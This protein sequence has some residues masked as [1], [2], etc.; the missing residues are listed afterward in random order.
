MISEALSAIV[1]GRGKIKQELGTKYLWIGIVLGSL[2][3]NF[4]ILSGHVSAYDNDSHD[5]IKTLN[6]KMFDSSGNS[7]SISDNF[8]TRKSLLTKASFSN[9]NPE[10]EIPVIESITVSP[11][12][13]TKGD[14]V[15][16]NIAVAY[17][18]SSGLKYSWSEVGNLV[19]SLNGAD[20][21][22]PSFI[23]PHV[24]GETNVT[25][26]VTVTNETGRTSSE[27]I[28]A[29]IKPSNTAAKI[30]SIVFITQ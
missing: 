13:S 30:T 4:D 28:T 24:R 16:L 20:T 7:N 6:S 8:D 26:C 14:K 15:I 5:R 3:S 12:P 10:E 11:N 18:N 17:K 21:P 22:S 25:L 1:G 2:F 19:V 23:A 9:N 27:N 29:I